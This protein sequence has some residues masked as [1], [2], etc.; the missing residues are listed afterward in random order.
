MSDLVS[1]LG[2]S[3]VGTIWNNLPICAAYH[4][5]KMATASYIVGILKLML[6]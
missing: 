1:S 5:S 4:L 2:T 6:T 3:F